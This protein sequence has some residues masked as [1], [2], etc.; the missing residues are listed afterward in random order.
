M[1]KVLLNVVFVG[2]SDA[3]RLVGFYLQEAVGCAPAFMG[4]AVVGAFAVLV[5]H[6]VSAGSA[7]FALHNGAHTLVGKVLYVKQCSVH[8]LRPPPAGSG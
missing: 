1:F 2:V 4:F 8:G 5:P 6:T 3:S 7:R